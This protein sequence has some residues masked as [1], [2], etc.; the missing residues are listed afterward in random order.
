MDPVYTIAGRRIK[1]PSSF[2]IEFY[3]IT[4]IDRLVSGD[5]CGELIAKKRKFYFKY[6]AISSDE[7]ENILEAIWN[8]NSIFFPFTYVDN[9]K[10]KSAIVYS[11][12]IPREFARPGGKWIW[13]NVTFDLIEQ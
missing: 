13:K 10:Q 4:N 9:N 2:K 3:N 5:A 6:D 1:N 7:L 8:T 11:G 12:S